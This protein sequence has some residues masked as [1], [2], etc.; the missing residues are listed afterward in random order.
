MSARATNSNSTRLTPHIQLI[1]I[2][3]LGYHVVIMLLKSTFLLQFRR[4][5]PLP[6]FQRLCD[7]FLA[8]L[9]VWT[10][11]GIVGGMTVCLPL[12][13]NWDPEAPIWTCENRLWFWMGHGIAHVIT[14]IL[15]FIMPMPL[16][17]TLPLPPL[18]K[19]VLIG[20]FSLGFLFVLP[21]PPL[22]CLDNN[23]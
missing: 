3:S 7:I 20:V 1:F 19:V 23:L 11:A 22:P 5:F 12:S 10:V 16:L 4:V 8:F 2:S 9:A 6:N 21:I 15:I 14:D 17:K 18:H 13:K